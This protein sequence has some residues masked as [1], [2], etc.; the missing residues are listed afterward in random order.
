[1]SNQVVPGTTPA[2]TTRNSDKVKFMTIPE[3][4]AL[5]KIDQIGVIRNPNTGKLF[6]ELVGT[7]IKLKVEQNI[8]LHAPIRFLYEDGLVDEGCIVNVKSD[9]T[10]A[11]L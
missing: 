5:Y 9:N 8:D 11:T 2:A 1:M 6:A 10:I 3:L 7:G 4:K